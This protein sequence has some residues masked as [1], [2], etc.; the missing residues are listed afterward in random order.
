MAALVRSQRSLEAATRRIETEIPQLGSDLI[1]IIQLANDTKIVDRAF[2]DAAVRQA[3]ERLQHVHFDEAA[4]KENRWRRFLYCMQT[5]RDL[6]ESVGLLALLIGGAMACQLLVPNWGS[7]ANRLMKPWDFVP[8]VGKVAIVEVKPGDTEV[9]I[10]ASLEIAAEIKNPKG[11]AFEGKI[12]ITPEGEPE[13]PQV[14]APD[15][16]S[17]HYKVTLPAITKPLK[18]RVEIGDWQSKVYAVQIREKPTINEVDVKFHY[19]DYLGR[20]D[21]S[22]TLKDADLTPAIYGGRIADPSFGGR[23][24]RLYRVG[25]AEAQRANRGRRPSSGHRRGA[26]VARR[27]LYGSPGQYCREQHPNPRLNKITVIP[28]QPPGVELIK[29]ARKESAAPAGVPALILRDG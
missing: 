21:D 17:A 6:I 8:S 27:Q 5:P 26:A 19:P 3:A 20:A 9:L 23:E 24:R 28:D 4:T 14:M 16:T 13:S 29:P 1:N 22:L 2:C 7:A 12:Y 25:R 10:G 18:Y 15:E 11:N